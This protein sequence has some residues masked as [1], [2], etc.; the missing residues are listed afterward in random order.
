MS[1]VGVSICD[2]VGVW[3]RNRQT[4]KLI[5]GGELEGSLGAMGM[6]YLLVVVKMGQTHLLKLINGLS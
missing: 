1:W 5:G 6:C 2:S 3:G 4:L